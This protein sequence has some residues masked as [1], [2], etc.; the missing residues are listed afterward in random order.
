MTD[1]IDSLQRDRSAVVSAAYAHA[2]NVREILR[3]RCD[4]AGED[5]IGR[6]VFR[7]RSRVNRRRRIAVDVLC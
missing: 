5:E 6:L 7:A 4:E 2:Q 3:D 1:A